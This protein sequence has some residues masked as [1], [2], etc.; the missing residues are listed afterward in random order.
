M[1]DYAAATASQVAKPMPELGRLKA[2]AERIAKCR[3]AVSY[4]I[5]RF[6]GPQPENPEGKTDCLDNYRNDLDT[7]FAQIERLEQAVS[8]L[9]YIG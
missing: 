9:E 3:S 7:L 6:H 1:M 4:F 5:E 2:A 8:Q